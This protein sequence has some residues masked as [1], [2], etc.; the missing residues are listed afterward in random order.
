M[1]RL[2]SHYVNIPEPGGRLSKSGGSE[3]GVPIGSSYLQLNA[4]N[5][6]TSA[7]M[8]NEIDNYS[9]SQRQSRMTRGNWVS[10]DDN[11]PNRTSNSF[12]NLTKKHLPRI[13][14]AL[15]SHSNGNVSF[16]SSFPTNSTNLKE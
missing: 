14:E 8:L 9:P 7:P 2:C 15:P 11:S 4:L 16:K 5:L 3:D 10:P 12:V 6:Q 1:F 13:L